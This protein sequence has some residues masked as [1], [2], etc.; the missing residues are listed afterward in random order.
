MRILYIDHY[1]GSPSLGME[2]RPYYLAREWV[3]GGHDVRI[4]G[5]DYSHLRIRQ[6]AATP[7][8][9]AVEDGVAYTWLR[10]PHY[11]G[12]GVGRAWNIAT[13]VGRLWGACESL[14]RD[15]RPDVV[16]ASSTYPMDIWPA[17]RLAR[18]AHARLAFELHDV[19]P[20][21]PIELGGM[22]PRHPFIR[23]CAKAERDMCRHADVVVSIL[24]AVASHLQSLGLDLAKLHVVPNGIDPTEWTGSGQ[25]LEA[26]VEKTLG[27][28]RD[29]G[30]LVVG[31]AG[32][33]GVAN[34]LDTLLDAARLLVNDRFRFILVGDGS[35][36]GRLQERVR[37]E[38]LRNVSLLPPIP[39]SQMP[40]FLGRLD[41]AYIGLQRQP[42]FRFGVSPNKLI[43]YMMGGC[44]VLS[45]IEAAND[46]VTEAGCG[47]S[48]A[49]ESAS[50]VEQGLR[51]LAALPV[52]TRRAMGERGRRHALS[53]H[54]WPVL[55][56]RFMAALAS[57]VTR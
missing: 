10:T 17:R 29:A 13:F 36:K 25:P 9:P 31:Y 40:A 20:A 18:L 28:A 33:H 4:V 11:R 45:A 26:S 8:A 21:S 51:A 12:N 47:V 24:P 55:A 19:W 23:L 7:L 1:A 54:T 38:G 6:P 37:R 42:V 34:A 49:A 35:E 44:A 53:H 15:M 57:P 22:S 56:E 16:I 27:E 52:A 43:D 32:A 3:R 48:V 39:K 2:F 50:G 30:D 46:M 14:A 5:A 41:I